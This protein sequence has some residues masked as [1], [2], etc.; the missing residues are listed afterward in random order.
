MVLLKMFA[1]NVFVFGCLFGG[2][3]SVFEWDNY[4]QLERPVSF[5][6]AEHS[7][8]SMVLG[9]NGCFKTVIAFCP[10]YELD[11]CDGNCSILTEFPAGSGQ[12]M[13]LC[14]IYTE[15]RQEEFTYLK[16]VE[17]PTGAPG[18]RGEPYEIVD[19]RLKYI[20]NNSPCQ[21]V[22]GNLTCPSGSAVGQYPGDQ[23][24]HDVSVGGG[25]GSGG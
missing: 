5:R 4:L 13:W 7:E 16:C 24:D 8:C 22:T 23:I 11:A 19:C 12:M 21:G 10:E 20:C 15:G 1:Q 17:S 6:I 2:I 9:G 3:A 25:C 14:D 18:C